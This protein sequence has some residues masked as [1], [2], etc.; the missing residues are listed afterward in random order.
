MEKSKLVFVIEPNQII[1][2][3]QNISHVFDFQEH[4][5]VAGVICNQT[6]ISA[7][8]RSFLSKNQLHRLP[9]IVIFANDLVHEQLVSQ[10]DLHI[11]LASRMHVKSAVN[12]SFN[13]LAM[14]EPGLLLQ[15]QILFWHMGVYIEMF[16]TINLLHIKNL[17]HI[18][19]RSLSSANSLDE[20]HLIAQ[21]NRSDLYGKIMQTLKQINYI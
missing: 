13:Y 8:I 16:T 18:D 5:M 10:A 7:S 17:L 19:H 6:E 3:Y 15:Y 20:L 1:L 11:D 2:L 12:E 21:T 4:E 9:A 14:L